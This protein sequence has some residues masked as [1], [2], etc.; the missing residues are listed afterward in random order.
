MKEAP[1]YAAIEARFAAYLRDPRAA[2]PPAGVDPTRAAV[3]ARLVH[4]NVDTLLAQCFPVLKSVC[5]D[6]RWQALIRDFLARHRAHTP[7]FPRLPQELVSFLAA[8]TRETDPAWFAELADYEWLEMECAQ[9]PRE[10][11]EL[12]CV[13]ADADLLEDVPILNPLA[14]ARAY[15]HPVHTI[16]PG[17]VPDAP[18]PE[19]VW[20]VVYRR[21]DDRVSFLHLN[22][23]SARL[24]ELLLRNADRRNG[25][26]LL[27]QIADELQHPRPAQLIEAG[28]GVLADLAARELLLGASRAFVG[29]E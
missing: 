24:V 16:A 11:D 1:G 23:V 25:R 15:R 7:L 5:E 22:A 13:D 20:L 29:P 26:A 19:P 9:D 4:H 21:R 12:A 18:S 10:L 17:R 3:Y 27:R 14:R 6:A 2:A 8:G 28:R